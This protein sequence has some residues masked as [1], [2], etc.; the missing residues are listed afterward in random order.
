[1][2]VDRQKIKLMLHHSSQ[3]EVSVIATEN[4]P[5]SIFTMNVNCGVRLVAN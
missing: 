4:L 5:S 3:T 2:F 1:M